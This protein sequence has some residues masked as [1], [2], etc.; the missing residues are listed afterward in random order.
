VSNLPKITTQRRPAG[1][2]TYDLSTAS[3]MSPRMHLFLLNTF[4]GQ[5][6]S[7]LLILKI[8]WIKLCINT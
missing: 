5:M 2:R 3:S 4:S 1:S 7:R 8:S 6:A